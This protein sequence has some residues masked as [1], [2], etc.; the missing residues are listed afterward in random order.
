MKVGL[1]TKLPVYIVLLFIIILCLFALLYNHV[2][3]LTDEE[4]KER[5]INSCSKWQDLEFIGRVTQI[6]KG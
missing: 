3:S 5:K 2:F 1:L 6:K 4:I